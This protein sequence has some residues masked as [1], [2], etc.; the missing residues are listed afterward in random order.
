MIAERGYRTK[1]EVGLDEN[2]L[3]GWVS[4]EVRKRKGQMEDVREEAMGMVMA[5]R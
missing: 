2:L 1:S 3:V 5:V 4:P